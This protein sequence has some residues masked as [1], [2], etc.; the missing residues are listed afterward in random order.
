MRIPVHGCCSAAVGCSKQVT[1]TAQS[2]PNKPPLALSKDGYG[3][4]AGFDDAPVKIEIYTEPQ[5][6]HCADLQ[7]TS[8]TSSP[9]TSPSATRRSPTAR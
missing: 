9:T 2:D 8:A 6:N 4:V 1:G 3:I 5:C 7:P